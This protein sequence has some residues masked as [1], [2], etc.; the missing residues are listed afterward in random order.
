MIAKVWIKTDTHISATYQ[1][2]PDK[3]NGKAI[4]R[5]IR[6]AVMQEHGPAVSVYDWQAI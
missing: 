6:S 1:S 4:K 5:H 3:L 2:I